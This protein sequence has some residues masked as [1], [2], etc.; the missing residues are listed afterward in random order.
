MKA[1]DRLVTLYGGGAEKARWQVKLSRGSYY[2]FDFKTNKLTPFKVKGERRGAKM[3][4]PD[5]SIWTTKD[6]QFKTDGP[7]SGNWVSFENNS[8]EM[9]FAE[10]AHVAKDTTAKDVREGLKSPKNPEWLLRGGFFF[11]VQ[12][13]GVKTVHHQEVSAAKYLLICFMP[14]EEQDG[15]PHAMMGMWHL[16]NAA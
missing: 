14:S 5:S 7:L 8:R 2:A 13:P 4:R 15:V 3:Q 6:N 10:A 11:E 9:H 12:S 1:F 16:V